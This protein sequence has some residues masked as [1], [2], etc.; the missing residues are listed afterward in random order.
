MAWKNLTEEIE[1]M[2]SGLEGCLQTDI[3]LTDLGELGLFGA[4]RRACGGG[5]KNSPYA[6]NEERR[7]ARLATFARYNAKRK[8][9]RGDRRPLSAEA[10][11]AKREKRR[12]T[13]AARLGRPA[14]PYS[15]AD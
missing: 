10:K 3:S 5:G 8:G 11:Q 2:F 1:E 6:T 13:Y 9:G 15:R 12:A 7:S 4:S 14:R